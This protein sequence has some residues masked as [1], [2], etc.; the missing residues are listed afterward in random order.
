VDRQTIIF[1]LAFAKG[2]N[3]QMKNE[4]QETENNVTVFIGPWV[5]CL[6]CGCCI[7]FGYLLG[8]ISTITLNF[9]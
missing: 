5:F 3:K 9:H 1:C 7:L 2:V 8:S 6:I 4:N